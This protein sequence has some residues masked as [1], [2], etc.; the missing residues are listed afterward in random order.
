[1]RRDGL[2]FEVDTAAANRLFDELS[3]TDQEATRAV[4]GALRESGNIIRRAAQRS[5]SSVSS[6]R[7]KR[8]L[9]K[10]VVYKDLGGVRVDIFQGDY[11][12]KGDK[13]KYFNLAWFEKGT[14]EGRGRNGRFHRA[15]PAKPFF[16]KAVAASQ[17]QAQ[18]NL[19]DAVLKHINK[20]VSRR[21]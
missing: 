15:T 13:K 6:D 8:R 18:K 20:V 7:R 11:L 14:K 12:D 4:R 1:M 9:I 17:E 5:L 21:K 19:G 3:M 2:R 10:V 16:A